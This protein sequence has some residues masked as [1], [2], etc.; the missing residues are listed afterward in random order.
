MFWGKNTYKTLLGPTHLLISEKS[1]TYTIFWQVIGDKIRI[2]VSGNMKSMASAMETPNF[3]S[4]V[5]R[6]TFVRKYSS[7]RKLEVLGLGVQPDKTVN[8][9]FKKK[10]MSTRRRP[11]SQ[12]PR[13]CDDAQWFQIAQTH[14]K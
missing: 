13:H 4:T 14:Q 3:R 5:F 11:R 2:Y 10:D 12:A 6:P 7:M 1:A 9:L 8:S